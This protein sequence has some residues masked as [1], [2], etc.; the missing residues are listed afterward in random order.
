MR[1]TVDAALC[2]G[3]ARCYAVAPDVFAEGP[4]GENRDA[5][6]TVEVLPGQEEAVEDAAGVCP[7]QAIRVFLNGSGTA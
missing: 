6:R 1:Y 3:Q 7:E 5:G 2:S 4:D